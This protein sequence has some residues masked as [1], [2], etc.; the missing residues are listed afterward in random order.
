MNKI[1]LILLFSIIIMN[2]KTIPSKTQNIKDLTITPEDIELVK[3]DSG[4]MLYVRAKKDIK[5]IKLFPYTHDPEGKITI[6]G[7]R[8]KTFNEINGNE[9]ISYGKNPVKNDQNLLIDSTPEPHQSFGHAFSFL[10][11]Y[12]LLYGYSHVGNETI[13]NL[14]SGTYF[15]I[16]TFPLKYISYD[17]GYCDNPFNLVLDF[18]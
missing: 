8:S 10:I 5:S 11:S 1:I 4:F 15:N 3:I 7:Y 14:V 9:Y 2:C 6:F 16:C 18:D 13:V 17:D 12:E